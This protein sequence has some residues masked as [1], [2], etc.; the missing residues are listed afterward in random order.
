MELAVRES[1]WA[2]T[3]VRPLQ[4]RRKAFAAPGAAK[5][6]ADRVLPLAVLAR[7]VLR[8]RAMDVAQDRPTGAQ[9]S[10]APAAA[11]FRAVFLPE[12]AEVARVPGS[13]AASRASER[14]VG[15][16]AELML[17]ARQRAVA[18]GMRA[19][20]LATGATRPGA[21]ATRVA[22]PVTAV[23]R[24]VE[25][26]SESHPP[27]ATVIATKLPVALGNAAERERARQS[28]A[29]EFGAA[30]DPPLGNGG[31]AILDRASVQQP[32]PWSTVAA[33]TA[34]VSSSSSVRRGRV[35][36]DQRSPAVA[37]RS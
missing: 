28:L 33:D 34:V 11:E 20:A 23:R 15:R 21:L 13:A 16:R 5:E 26:A 29:A 19:V 22:A 2:A 17:G 24:R 4:E 8:A 31:L 14:Y 9:V 30:T 25:P 7:D 3:R 10:G 18:A 12:V 6:S 27:G 37:A 35:R 36:T 1:C 32:A